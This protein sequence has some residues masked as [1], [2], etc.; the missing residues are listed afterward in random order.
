MRTD[1]LLVPC[2]SEMQSQR[3]PGPLSR[4]SDVSSIPKPTTDR[5]DPAHVLSAGELATWY[6]ASRRDHTIGPEQRA[7]LR[8]R[9]ARGS[10]PARPVV[11]DRKARD[12]GDTRGLTAG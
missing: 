11:G 6:R 9:R 8:F 10:G 1:F 4:S 7:V 12:S 5:T 2:N 3:V